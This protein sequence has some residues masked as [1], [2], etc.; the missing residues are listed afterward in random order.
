M[1][2]PELITVEDFFSPPERAAA[3][4][5]PDGNRIA[6]LAP[7]RNRLNVWVVDV[8]GN[9]TPRCVTADETRSV[10]IYQWT[11]DSRWLLYLQDGGGDEN[12]HVYR[13]DPD[14]PEATAVDLTPFPGARAHFE[15]LRGRPG[16]AMV[17]TNNRTPELLDAYELD[18]ATGDL[19]LLAENPGTVVG[20]ISG[21]NGELFTNTLTADGDVE[22]SQWDS[23]TGT[24]RP[25][26]VYEGRDYPIGIHPVAVSP[27]GS[28][29]WLGSY[30][31]SDRLRLARVDVDSGE[32]TV[33]DSHPTHELGAQI[34]LPSPF[35][36][37][38]QTGDL[39]GARYYGE[40]QLIH[41]LDEGFAEVLDALT[42]L[43]DGDLAEMSC[44]DS[45]QRWVVGFS[46]DRDPAVTYFYDH[47]TGASR[48]LFRPYPQLDP[49]SLAPMTPVAVTARDGL[50]LHGYLTLPLGVEPANLPMVL[51]VHGGP[52]ARDCWGYQPLS[53]IHI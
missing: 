8:D 48:L 43:S 38:E 33:I 14:A 44:D 4:I 28:G 31:D 19:T 52:W 53:L 2:L 30:Q 10:Y 32:E 16:R 5:S 9:D 39:I 12:W 25:I 6:Y 40:R 36:I 27:D 42:N 29:L 45:G 34:M 21:P 7:W 1:A 11:H 22:I 49:E 37:S 41:A 47:A 24:L 13:V 3:K 35:I 23:A 51:L 17:Q 18:I 50:E 46:H 26:K 20:W 15:L